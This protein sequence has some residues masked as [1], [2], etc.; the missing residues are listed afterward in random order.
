MCDRCGGSGRI[1]TWCGRAGQG[2]LVGPCPRCSPTEQIKSFLTKLNGRH[3]TG[4]VNNGTGTS[5]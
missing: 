2:G 4:G 5:S 3:L 1:A